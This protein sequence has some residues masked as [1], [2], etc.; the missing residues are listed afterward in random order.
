MQQKHIKMAL[1]GYGLTSFSWGSLVGLINFR[2]AK[3]TDK[4]HENIDKNKTLSLFC[5]QKGFSTGILWP[6]T[7]P[8]CIL[9]PTTILWPTGYNGYRFTD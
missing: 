3:M 5:I 6:L 8:H 7:M 9:R 2:N 1:L 4:L